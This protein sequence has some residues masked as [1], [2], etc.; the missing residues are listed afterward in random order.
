MRKTEK[1]YWVNGHQVRG[2]KR[3]FFTFSLFNIGVMI[4]NFAPF[5]EVYKLVEEIEYKTLQD[6]FDSD[7]LHMLD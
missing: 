2:N 3:H 1:K 5:I 6:C 7:H 4:I